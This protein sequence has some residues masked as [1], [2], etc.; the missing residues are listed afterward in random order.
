MVD[1][2]DVGGDG[3]RDCLNIALFGNKGANPSAEFELRLE[4]QGTKADRIQI[5]N[6]PLTQQIVDKYDIIILDRLIRTYTAD[7]AKPC[8]AG[9]ATVAATAMTSATAARPPMSST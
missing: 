7:E 3:I 1:D 2:V 4:A 6:T 9:S 8:R 5:D